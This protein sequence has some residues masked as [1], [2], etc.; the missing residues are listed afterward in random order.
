MVPRRFVNARYL[1]VEA[2]FN[3]EQAL[4]WYSHVLLPYTSTLC[5]WDKSRSGIYIGHLTR[6]IRVDLEKKES[7]VVIGALDDVPSGW[8]KELPKNAVF[9]DGAFDSLPLAYGYLCVGAGYNIFWELYL[10]NLN[11][12]HIPLQKRYDDQFRRAGRWNRMI[13]N[14]EQLI[15]IVHF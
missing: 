6:S 4:S 14:R 13:H 2:L 15:R 8:R 5:E 7:M 12:M 1:R 10:L 9:I 3:Y 11:A